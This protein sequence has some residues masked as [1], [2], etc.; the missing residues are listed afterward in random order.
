VA[1]F[2]DDIEHR[3]RLARSGGAKREIGCVAGMVAAD[4]EIVA[5][6]L[7]EQPRFPGGSTKTCQL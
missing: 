5:V 2:D 3:A 1:N 4:V 7:P 6:V